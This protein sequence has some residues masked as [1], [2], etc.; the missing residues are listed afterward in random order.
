MVTHRQHSRLRELNP[1]GFPSTSDFKDFTLAVF[2]RNPIK[3]FSVFIFIFTPTAKRGGALLLVGGLAAFLVSRKN[4]QCRL[5]TPAAERSLQSPLSCSELPTYSGALL[6]HPGCSP[7][8]ESPRRLHSCV[9]PQP[10]SI[11]RIRNVQSSSDNSDQSRRPAEMVDSLFVRAS[12]CGCRI[13][14]DG[15]RKPSCANRNNGRHRRRCYR[16]KCSCC[17]GCVCQVEERRHRQFHFHHN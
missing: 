3:I 2:R 13:C 7:Q 6:W 12:G 14:C 5:L 8:L 4:R 1:A 17:V 16:S 15:C 10:I 9:P 11:R